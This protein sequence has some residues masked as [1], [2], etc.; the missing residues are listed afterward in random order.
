MSKRDIN[1]DY[2]SE[3]DKGYHEDYFVIKHCLKYE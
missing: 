2:W 3:C 1:V